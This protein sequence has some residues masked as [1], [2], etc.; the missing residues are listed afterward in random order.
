MDA[1]QCSRCMVR[2]SISEF[3]K[4]AAGKDG[5]QSWCRSCMAAKARERRAANPDSVRAYNLQYRIERGEVARAATARWRAANS[6]RVAAQKREWAAAN[7]EAIRQSRLRNAEKR[8]ETLA[9]WKAANRGKVRE[10]QRR[11]RSAGY[12]GVVGHV[13]G[14]QLWTSQ[15][16]ACA[17]CSKLIDVTLKWPHPQSISLDHRVALS[18][19]GPHETG[20]CQ[21]VH[22]VCNMQKGDR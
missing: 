11:R 1:K 20:N 8:A 16:G 15:R 13:D 19:G 4:R 5:H 14:E 6:E 22:L 2:R 12:G 3:N 9:R 18:L 10:Y 17:L 21:W 7:R